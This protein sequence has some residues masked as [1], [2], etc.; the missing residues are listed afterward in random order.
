MEELFFETVCYG[1]HPVCVGEAATEK[2]PTH[3]KNEG[4]RQTIAAQ[5][6]GRYLRALRNSKASEKRLTGG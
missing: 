3:L 2:S 1:L 4:N 6:F 5:A